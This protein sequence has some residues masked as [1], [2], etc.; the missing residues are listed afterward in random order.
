MKRSK[1]L[2]T[3]MD[4]STIN[5]CNKI[6]TSDFCC[7]KMNKEHKELRNENLIDHSIIYNQRWRSFTIYYNEEAEQRDR[8][9]LTDI[10]WCPW[11]GTKLRK[12]LSDQWYD[13]L[14]KEYGI[15]DPIVDDRKK[16]PAEFWT[17][18]WWKKR[19]L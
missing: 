3:L 19:G 7:D 11:C 10:L 15:C 2:L 1:N 12:E 5:R 14:E 6:S 8:E 16:V 13:I 9:M 17:D 4:A 18:E